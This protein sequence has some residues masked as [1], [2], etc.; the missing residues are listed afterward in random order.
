MSSNRLK[1]NGAKLS[2]L[3]INQGTET[4]RK[5]LDSKHSPAN[6][7]AV[8]NANRAIL[9]TLRT[10]RVINPEQMNLL[11]PPPGMPPTTSSDYDISL[12]FILIRNICGLRAPVTTGSWDANP[13]SSDRSPEAIG[14]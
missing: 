9:N 5:Y 3:I 12:L 4:M 6:L 14:W 13:P 7:P 2:C 11:F 10:N 1:S 8:L